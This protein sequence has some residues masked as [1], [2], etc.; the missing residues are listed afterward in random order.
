MRPITRGTVEINVDSCKGCD[1]CI[2][3]CPVDALIMS[4]DVNVLGYHYPLLAPG[5]TG[6]TACQK[7]C[8][9]FIFAVYRFDEGIYIDDQAKV[10]RL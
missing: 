1:L 4:K 6:C 9:D 2:P 8:P 5:C 7:V 10:V 3:A